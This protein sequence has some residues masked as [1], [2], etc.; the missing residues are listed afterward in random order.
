MDEKGKSYKVNE[1]VL[2]I[3]VMC[4]GN[5]TVEQI[6]D[7]LM[8]VSDSGKRKVSDDVYTVIMNLEHF[9]LVEKT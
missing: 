5:R 1:T 7:E 2:T 4:D 8:K 6:I 3:W 9:G